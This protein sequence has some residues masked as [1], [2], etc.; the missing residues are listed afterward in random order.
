MRL[1]Q[2][3]KY[4]A[5]QKLEAQPGSSNR[6]GTHKSRET[7]DQHR[8]REEH[9]PQDSILASTRRNEVTSRQCASVLQQSGENPKAPRTRRKGKNPKDEQT[10]WTSGNPMVV[11][12]QQTGVNLETK[13]ARSPMLT[14]MGVNARTKSTHLNQDAKSSSGNVF[15]IL[16]RGADLRDMLN[17]RRD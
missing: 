17:K 11:R 5:P 9:S 8:Q 6:H 12:N 13:V 16:G 10:Q 4:R 3:V 14:S 15:Q 2:C 1:T 7:N